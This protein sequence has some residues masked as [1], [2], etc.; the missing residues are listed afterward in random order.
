MAMQDQYNR[1]HQDNGCQQ[2]QS[3]SYKE[4]QENRKKQDEY[5]EAM[6]LMS[7]RVTAGW[8]VQMGQYRLNDSVPYLNDDMERQMQAAKAAALAKE[9]TGY[10]KDMV[11]FKKA[12][13]IQVM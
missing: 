2:G 7:R 5:S 12:S 6:D 3:K 9:I 11:T 4:L 8:L 1:I 13:D 10:C